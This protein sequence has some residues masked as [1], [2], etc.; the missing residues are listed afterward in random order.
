VLFLVLANQISNYV[1]RQA[2]DVA[3]GCQLAVCAGIRRTGTKRGGSY[4]GPA[5]AQFRI[6]RM[7]VNSRCLFAYG[8]TANAGLNPGCSSRIINLTPLAVCYAAIVSRVEHELHE[9]RLDLSLS[10]VQDVS[11]MTC[12]SCHVKMNISRAK[13][14]RIVSSPAALHLIG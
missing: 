5:A 4:L 12:G 3:A 9:P 6:I 11:L 14:K 13:A 8:N 1:G 7:S 10:L 2:A